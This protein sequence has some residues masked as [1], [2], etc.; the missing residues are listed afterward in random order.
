[1]S[2]VVLRREDAEQ[3]RECLYQ[4]A[5]D[6]DDTH[7]MPLRGLVTAINA[8]LNEPAPFEQTGDGA[9]VVGDGSTYYSVTNKDID[10]FGRIIHVY[11]DCDA[12]NS[13]ECI[14]AEAATARAVALAILEL[15]DGDDDAR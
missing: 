11:E 12:G 4:A 13:R 6:A 14:G 7:W 10:T 8:A 3:M 1:M 15:T 2:H 9:L 5:F